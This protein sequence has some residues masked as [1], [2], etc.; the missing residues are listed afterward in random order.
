M[1]RVQGKTL[2]IL[3][4]RNNEAL[5]SNVQMQ[6]RQLEHEEDARCSLR[7]REP[8]S[9]CSDETNQ[10]LED[11]R[12][13]LVTEVTSEV[14]RWDEQVHALRT[15]LSLHA[16]HS[17]DVTQQQSQE[18]GGPHS[19]WQDGFRKHSNIGR[20]S[21]NLELLNQSLDQ[22]LIKLD[23]EKQNFYEKWNV[24]TNPGH[25]KASK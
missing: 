17:E 14:W 20:C 5:N 2:S 6:V 13:I 9:R 12:E 18:Y 10:A 8:L 25:R 16:Q 21:K 23:N 3:S 19:T 22:R 15:E 24:T 11:R 4:A 7:P 1:K